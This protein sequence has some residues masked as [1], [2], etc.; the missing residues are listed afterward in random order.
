MRTISQA[1]YDRIEH[2]KTCAPDDFW[3]QVRRTVNGK[4][5][6]EEQIAMIR[7]AIR[8]ALQF[9]PHD[10]LLD[11]C[12]G[13]GALS[14]FFFDDL[15]AYLGVDISPPLIEIAIYNFQRDKTHAFNCVP[16]STYVIEEI[17]PER[18]TKC[19]CYG[20]FAY[21]SSHDVQHELCNLRNRF[22]NLKKMFIGAIPDRDKAHLF[23]RKKV[24]FSLDDHGS[25]LGRWYTQDEIIALADACGWQAVCKCMPDNYYQ[26]HYRFDAILTPKV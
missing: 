11:L 5:V 7:T 6:P 12:C 2:P 1:H 13:N 9:H 3:G 19:L 17:N 18:F 22:F 14:S 4:P 15:A 10:T 20:S 25:T 8:E 23:F 16:L 21:L 26:S 24:S